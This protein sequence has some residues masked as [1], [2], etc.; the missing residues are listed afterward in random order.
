MYNYVDS[1]MLKAVTQGSYGTSFLLK[2]RE[3]KL[4]PGW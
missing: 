1:K 2:Q 4:G 3:E